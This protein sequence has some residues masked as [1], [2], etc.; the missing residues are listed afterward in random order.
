MNEVWKKYRLKYLAKVS[1]LTNIPNLT[2][3]SEVTFLPMNYI[4]N[5]Y[6]IPNTDNLANFNTSYNSFKSG[7]ILMAKVTPCF[8]NGNITIAENLVNGFGYGT[9]EIFVIRANKE[10]LLNRFLIYLLQEYNFKYFATS[11]MTG[12]A[13]LKRVPSSF[14][15][16]YFFD[17]PDLEKQKAIANILDQKCKKIDILIS[18]EET[19]ITELKEYKKSIIQKAVTKGIK[20]SRKLKNSGIEW[21]GDIPEEWEIYR[22]KNIFTIQGGNGFPIEEQ[23]KETGDLPFFKNSDINDESFF[24]EIA[25]N[26]LMYDDATRLDLNIIPK[27]SI[28]MG[29]IGESL[30]KNHRKINLCECLI[31]NNMQALII[32]S[33]DNIEYLKYI[34]KCIDMVWFDNGGTIP[35][36]NNK[37]FLAS[38]LA[39]SSI[40]EQKEI[41]E[42]LDKKTNIVGNLISLKQQKIAELKEYKKSLI[43]EYVTGKK[44]PPK[45]DAK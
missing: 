32:K 23:G 22:V 27:N 16:G 20:K 4:R 10:K 41:A 18:L 33:N 8:E 31:D 36:V 7:D 11:E 43:Y 19:A 29:K 2:D 35:S 37:Y 44:Q 42:Y 15:E 3:D 39:L 26:Y 6:F 28:V 40:T 13:G 9:S 38:W 12:V 14:V 34:S 25:K 5:G 17:I 1:P 21:I 24:V 30:K 45:K